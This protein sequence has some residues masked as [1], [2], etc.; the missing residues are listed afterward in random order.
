MVI[1]FKEELAKP[2]V[3]RGRCG[4]TPSFSCRKLKHSSEGEVSLLE[5]RSRKDWRR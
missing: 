2:P 4:E 3:S 1:V 5:L